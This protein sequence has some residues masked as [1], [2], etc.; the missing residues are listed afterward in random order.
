MRDG[1]GIA[2]VRPDEV[3]LGQAD[4]GGVPAIVQHVFRASPL[5]RVEVQLVDTH[6]SLDVTLPPESAG[7]QIA[8]GQ[9]VSLNFTKFNVLQG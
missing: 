2:Y 5:P 4:A 8:K 9:R 3:I 6:V 1:S 7:A